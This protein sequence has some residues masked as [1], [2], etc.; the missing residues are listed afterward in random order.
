MARCFVGACCTL[1]ILATNL[2]ALEAVGMLKQVDTDKNIVIV[3]AGGQDRTLKAD[4]NL[5]VVDEQGKALADGLKAKELKAG[6]T[7]TITV[8]REN[9]ELILK[10]LR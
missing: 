8:E 7:V 5:K 10:Q 6:A 1:L 4:P 3:F 2:V 9:Q